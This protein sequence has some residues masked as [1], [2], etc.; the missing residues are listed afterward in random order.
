MNEARATGPSNLIARDGQEEIE[1]QDSRHGLRFEQSG[2]SG[3][4]PATSATTGFELAAR[5]DSIERMREVARCTP[6]KDYQALLIEHQ[7][8]VMS[9]HQGESFTRKDE[10]RLQ[11]LRWEIQRVHDARHGDGLDLM[12]A[13]ADAHERLLERISHRVD[14]FT[15]LQKGQRRK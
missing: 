11:L 15:Q 7:S 10:L 2:W 8:L 6:E 1:S 4:G 14:Q 5:R 12:E 3:P 13:I 9:K